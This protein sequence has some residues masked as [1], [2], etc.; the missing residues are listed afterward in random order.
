ML[1]IK[2]GGGEN[3]NLDG[4]VT[5]LAGLDKNF[6]IVHGANVL[7]DHIS[8]KMGYRKQVIT[9]TSGYSSVFSDEPAIES[10][11]MAYSGLRNKRLVELCQGAGINA[12]GLTG[13]D[14]RIVQGQ[15]NKG[16]RVMENGKKMLKRDLSGKPLSINVELLNLLLDNGYTPVLTIPIIDENS[17][18][19]NSENDDIVCVLQQ[20][21]N[22]DT[23]IQLI[24]APGLMGDVDD[25]NSLLHKLDSGQLESMEQHA[26]GRIKRKLHGLKKLNEN[27][28]QK[29][30][31]CD[32]RTDSPISDGLA[33]AGTWIT[34]P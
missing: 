15:R 12:V 17:V 3:I 14:G 11:L 26:Q 22:A 28:V 16:I 27:G 5:N 34:N 23:V 10:I 20:T 1:I 29:I 13:L 18:A 2:I 21:L 32:G 4:I 7:R 19:I 9:S 33:G 24:E 31:V 8:E 30:I 25:S 6:I